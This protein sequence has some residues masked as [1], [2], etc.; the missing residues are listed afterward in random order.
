MLLQPNTE[1]ASSGAV[2]LRTANTVPAASPTATTAAVVATTATTAASST[3]S[4]T[5]ATTAAAA[6]TA[7]TTAA[8]AAAAA[9]GDIHA[10]RRTVHRHDAGIQRY[11]IQ[12]H[13]TGC[14]PR[15]CGGARQNA[16]SG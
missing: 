2:V 11:H 5:Y 12:Q 13:G 14:V 3:A 1:R 7:A 6:T 15:R 8:T 4:T 16:H 9:A 10:A